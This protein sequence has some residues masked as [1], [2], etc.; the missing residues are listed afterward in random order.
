MLAPLISATDQMFSWFCNVFFKY[1]RD[2]LNSVQQRQGNVTKDTTG[3][4]MFI[5]CCSHMTD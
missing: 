4:K 5:S 3:Q 1:F 2:W